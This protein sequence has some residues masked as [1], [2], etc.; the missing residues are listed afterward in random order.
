MD[1]RVPRYKGTHGGCK[2]NRA[3]P[4]ETTE[5][6]EAQASGSLLHG[7]TPLPIFTGENIKREDEGFDKWFELFEEHTQFTGWKP[8]QKL[9]RLKVQLD[10]T[11]QQIVKMMPD[12]E[13]KSFEKVV[14]HL[15]K[16]F[17]PINIA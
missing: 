3:I 11:A 1:R 16:R 10:K 15:K 8:E 14:A 13:R 6:L 5:I 2:V 7:L 12:D 17:H 9:Y 4:Q